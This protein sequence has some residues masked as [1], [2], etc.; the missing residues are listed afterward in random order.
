MTVGE[1]IAALKAHPGDLR[2]FVMGYEGGLD[3]PVVGSVIDV[4]LNVHDSSVYGPHA[5]RG[6]GWEKPSGA[7]RGIVLSRSGR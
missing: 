6:E 4:D 3:D 1:L 7:V 5:P 2:V